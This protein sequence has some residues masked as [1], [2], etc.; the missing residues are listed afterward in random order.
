M[1]LPLV[2]ATDE[3]GRAAARRPGRRRRGRLAREPSRTPSSAPP[4]PLAPAALR[5][6]AAR[7]PRRDRPQHDRPR[8]DGRLLIID[9]GVLFPEDHQPGVDLILPDFDHIARPARRHRRRWCS[10]TATRTTSARCRTCCGCEAGHPARSARSSP[11]RWSRPSCAST[12]SQP[13]H[14][15]GHGGPASSGSAPFD[16]EFVAVNHSIPDALAVAVRTRGR[17]GAAHRRLQDGPAAARRPDHRPA[18]L[19]PAR[20]GRASTCSWST[21]PTPRCPGFTTSEREIGPVLDRVFAGAERRIIVA[22]FASH[23]HRVQQVL[24]AAVRAR[25]AGSPS[26]AARWCAT[27]ASPRDLGYLHVAGR[28]RGRPQGGRR[29]APT[30]RSC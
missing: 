17:H 30:T 20:R 19:R 9:C 3:R 22:C 27:W 16:C 1:R 6:V 21:P 24:D 28:R 29:P 4:P 11:W 2:A 7:R 8:D 14:A 26:S 25:P 18:R 10:P 12:G 13:V 15:R 5:V 23:V